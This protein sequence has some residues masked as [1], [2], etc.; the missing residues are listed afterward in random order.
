MVNDN[1]ARILDRFMLF[2]GGVAYGIDQLLEPP[3]LGA[4]C[5]GLE[6]RTIYVRDF[7]IMFIIVLFI[8]DI[9]GEFWFFRQE[10]F[11]PQHVMYWTGLDGE[12][13]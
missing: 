6:D 7:N 13:R 8:S 1:M 3:G 12:M 5:D 4:H 10:T 11:L 2:N 9:S